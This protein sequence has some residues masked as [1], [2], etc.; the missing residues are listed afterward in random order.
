MFNA[1]DRNRPETFK[2][3]PIY[4]PKV[5]TFTHHYRL[6]NLA[7]HEKENRKPKLLEKQE[8]LA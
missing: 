8:N 4:R 7:G 5:M 2:K 3:A 1:L 6:N